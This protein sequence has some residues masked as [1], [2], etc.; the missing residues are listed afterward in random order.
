MHN[1]FFTTDIIMLADEHS[2]RV[3]VLR[4]QTYTGIASS[5]SRGDGSLESFQCVNKALNGT[6]C[7]KLDGPT[8]LLVFPCRLEYVDYVAFFLAALY[9][10]YNICRSLWHW[11]VIAID[12]ESKRYVFLLHMIDKTYS[13]SPEHRAFV[14]DSLS[15]AAVAPDCSIAVENLATFVGVLTHRCFNFNVEHI[16]VS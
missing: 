11:C 14:L 7:P 9:H 2:P 6:P 13:Y 1:T 16:P 10:C 3:Q 12:V 5:I 8:E 4:A 15:T